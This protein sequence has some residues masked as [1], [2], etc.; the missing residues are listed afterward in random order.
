[1]SPVVFEALE[2]SGRRSLR[3]QAQIRLLGEL[4]PDVC[5]FQEANPVGA[6]AEALAAAIG[7]EFAF[8]PDLVGLKLFGVGIPVNLNSGLVTMSR[9]GLKRLE[10][11]SL[12]RKGVN[13]VHSWGSWQL[14]EERFALFCE[15]L[16]PAWGR[17]LLI[18]TH[19]HHGLEPTS[20]FMAE[21]E[22]QAGEL[23]LQPGVLS[24]IHS[25]LARGGER[26]AHELEVLLERLS[27]HEKRYEVVVLAGDFNCSPE[28]ELG[29]VLKNAGFRD[30]W[31]EAHPEGGG[32][33]FDGTVNEANH[34][35]QNRFP[36]TLVVEDLT[37]SAK[38]KEALLALA[39]RQ[40]HR[41]RRIDYI[42]LRSGAVPLE[43]KHVSLAGLP[44]SEGLAPSD[45]FA[46]C[47]DIG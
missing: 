24:E 39:Q 21:L 25:R 15:S 45:H 22:K 30:V 41:P 38:T 31:A 27:A 18:N 14:Q 34:L 28:S 23:E 47:A 43:L 2:P 4:N 32:L 8:Q 5:F 37:F 6:R 42:W 33:T 17:V 44:D 9:H 46:V 1:M 20:E 29:V 7:A 10:A 3:E 16:L 26:R 36:L 40:E 11:V 19:L 35:L 13:L 12:D